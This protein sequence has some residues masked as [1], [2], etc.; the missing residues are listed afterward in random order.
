MDTNS[1]LVTMRNPLHF[2]RDLLQQPLRISAWVLFL[3]LI[4]MASL[5]FWNK[6]LAQLVFITFMVSA[7]M[8]MALYA[9]FGFTGILGLG[10]IL[11]IPLLAWLLTHLPATDGAFRIYLLAL[12]L[13]IG[14]S[15]VLDIIDVWKFWPRKALCHEAQGCARVT[16]GNPGVVESG[17]NPDA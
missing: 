5:A 7:M 11:W 17:K 4:N 15:L 10:H 2:F 12:S 1:N 9:R 3:M 8:M 13:T 14:I 16:P 6:P